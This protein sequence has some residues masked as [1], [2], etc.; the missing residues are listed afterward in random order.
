MKKLLFVLYMSSLMFNAQAGQVISII[1]KYA[2]Q[3]ATIIF[4]PV[5][6]EEHEK[7]V[8]IFTQLATEHSALLE[9]LQQPNITSDNLQKHV[10]HLQQLHDQEDSAVFIASDAYIN[11]AHLGLSWFVNIYENEHAILETLSNTATAKSFVLDKTLKDC[12]NLF[13]RA[14]KD[15]RFRTR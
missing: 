7:E 8:V 2:D 10:A 3:A 13:C 4:K 6:E 1:N 14:I 9:A 11:K 15:E 5:S 12:E